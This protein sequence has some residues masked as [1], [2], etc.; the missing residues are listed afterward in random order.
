M[1]LRLGLSLVALVAVAGCD[2]LDPVP[3]PEGIPFGDYSAC[4]R[5]D[6]GPVS[7]YLFTVRSGGTVAGEGWVEGHANVIRHTAA[8]RRDDPA[9]AYYISD[10]TRDRSDVT[11][12]FSDDGPMP[13]RT[14]PAIGGTFTIEG[15][16][17]L[18]GRIPDEIEGTLSASAWGTHPVAFSR[19]G[20]A[21]CMPR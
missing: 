2:A 19:S 8:D 3:V 4:V 10:G 1:S 15:R 9:S 12:R 17:S 21:G 20:A 5:T 16:T 14:G 6:A 13:G 11:L 7:V 18:D